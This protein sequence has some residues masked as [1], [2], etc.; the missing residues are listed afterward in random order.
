MMIFLFVRRREWRLGNKNGYSSQYTE[1]VNLAQRCMGMKRFWNLKSHRPLGCV[2]FRIL[3]DDDSMYSL[4]ALSSPPLPPPPPPPTTIVVVIHYELSS[5][6][7][8]YLLW[9]F[10]NSTKE[11]CMHN[12]IWLGLWMRLCCW[13]GSMS[14]HRLIVLYVDVPNQSLCITRKYPSGCA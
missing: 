4:E 11:R 3:D 6:A 7:S 1:P 10:V 14:C 8:N 9:S 12:F 13:R 2:W 5:L